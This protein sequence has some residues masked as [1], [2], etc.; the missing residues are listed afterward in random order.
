MIENKYVFY[1]DELFA[2][3]DTGI[4]TFST[5]VASTW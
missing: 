2:V 5:K 3:N 1:Q 4:V